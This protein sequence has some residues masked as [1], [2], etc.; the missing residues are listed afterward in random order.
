MWLAFVTPIKYLGNYFGIQINH[1]LNDA[2]LKG[3]FEFD[4]FQQ[5]ITKIQEAKETFQ[6]AVCSLFCNRHL[7]TPVSQFQSS[8]IDR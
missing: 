3:V 5:E 1:I 4:I 2:W 8:F 7:C 6:Q